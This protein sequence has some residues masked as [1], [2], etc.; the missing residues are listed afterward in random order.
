VAS[1]I[2][3]LL[4]CPT[5][6]GPLDDVGEE[7]TC[8]TCARSYPF[9]NGVPNL[10]LTTLAEIEPSPPGLLARAITALV[11]IPVVYDLL[12]SLAGKEATYRRLAASLEGTAG[13]LVLDA[14]AG[15]GNLEELLPSSASYLWLDPDPQKLAGFRRK[16]DAT[17]ILG[18]ATRI[19]LKDDSVDWAICIGVSHHLDDRELSTML[20]ELRRVSREKI[21]F[22]DAVVTERLMSRLLWRY[23]R[24]RHPRTATSLKRELEAHFALESSEEFTVRHRYLLALAR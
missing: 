4:A 23:D 10:T 14:G 13:S 18:D 3:D 2:S 21:C 22:L 6:H 7:L 15:T 24:G 17:A 5:C 12:Q 1:E 16:S 11:A 20:S 9:V 8:E 19:P